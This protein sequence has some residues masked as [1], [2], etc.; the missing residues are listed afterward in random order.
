MKKFC[1]MKSTYPKEK[2]VRNSFTLKP[3]NFKKLSQYKNKSLLV[4]KALELYF[5][6]EK[7]LQDADDKWLRKTIKEAQEEIARGEYTIINPN[8]GD[9][10]DE[11][12]EET[13]WS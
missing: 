13:L 3:K 8:G 10:T 1:I 11:M 2:A 12:L 9:I 7:A 5:S 6:R 4:N